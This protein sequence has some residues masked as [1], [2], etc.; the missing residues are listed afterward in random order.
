MGRTPDPRF[1]PRIVKLS[2][3][4]VAAVALAVPAVVINPISGYTQPNPISGYRTNG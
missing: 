1:H 3:A 4:T 2:A